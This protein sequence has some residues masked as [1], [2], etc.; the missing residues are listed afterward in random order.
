[1]QYELM[2]S[3][4]CR[5]EFFHRGIMRPKCIYVLRFEFRKSMALGN[6]ISYLKYSRGVLFVQSE[7]VP[8]L[9][10]ALRKADISLWFCKCKYI[11]ICIYLER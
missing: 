6:D 8:T 11:Y 10:C 2:K 7:C 1:M 5:Q 4:Q 9:D 3:L